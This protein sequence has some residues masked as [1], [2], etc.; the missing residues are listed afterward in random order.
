MS[1]ASSRTVAADA[2]NRG[3][4]ALWGS[5]FAGVLIGVVLGVIGR[6][7][8]SDVTSDDTPSYAVTLSP[9]PDAAIGQRVTGEDHNLAMSPD[10][11]RVAFVATD[12][13]GRQQLWV[14]ELGDL[15]PRA[16]EG[17]EGADSPFWSPAGR[18]IAFF[19]AR[20]LQKISST[21]GVPVTLCE[22]SELYGGGGT[23]N[24]DDVIVFSGAGSLHRIS[25]SG[26]QPETIVHRQT[27]QLEWPAFL[28]DGE[29]ILYR[30]SGNI[31]YVRSLASGE[32]RVVGAGA[33]A[34]YALGHVVFWRNGVILAQPFDESKLALTGEPVPLA[35]SVPGTT[36]GAAFSISQDGT[37]VHQTG[38]SRAFS[39]LVW[40]DRSGRELGTLDE[41]ND[42]GDLQ[43]SPDGNRAA[44][45]ILDVSQ[46]G[47]D[48]WLYDTARALRTRMTHARGHDRA[49]F[50]S[51]DGQR[52]VFSSAREGR[53]NLYSSPVDNIGRQ[54][55][56]LADDM[57]K[58]PVHWSSDGRHILFAVNSGTSPTKSSDI[59]VLPLF[60][61]RRPFAV[62]DTPFE[63]RSAQVS[64]DGRW[65]TYTSNES[66]SD[67]V[68][69]TTFPNP[70]MRVRVSGEGGYWPRW[71]QDGREI[72]FRATAPRQSLMAAPVAV[73]N[74]QIEI[75]KAVP[76]FSVRTRNN[77]RYMYDVSADGNRFLVNAAPDLDPSEPLTLIVNWPEL[78]RR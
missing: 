68:Y 20:K 33:N 23:W 49:L 9:P 21:G 69:V 17:T 75:G 74:G 14:R 10:G 27:N 22:C 39:R 56:L 42:Y 4:I 41:P 48:L 36:G 72:F 7:S 54:E 24:R 2:R 60:G 19:A 28:P 31:T 29:H 62:L 40:F 63:E 55:V 43:L 46:N 51:P 52:V 59:W 70:E 65:L 37:L 44:A 57:D 53:A 5:A 77:Q 66:G 26:G 3:G 6:G 67:E 11:R 12:S 34:Q 38:L 64:P 35:E 1:D 32:E 73:R 61:E 58:E 78:L 76:L 30:G 8:F 25:A 13:N 45:S 15:A 47:R 71:R 16:L 18:F 50:W